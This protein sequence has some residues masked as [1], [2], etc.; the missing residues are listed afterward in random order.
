MMRVACIRSVPRSA[1]IILGP[2]QVREVLRE[3]R[4]TD[5]DS[6][7]D[8]IEEFIYDANGMEIRQRTDHDADGVFYIRSTSYTPDGQVASEGTDADGDGVDEIVRLS[9]SYKNS[10]F[11]SD[12]Y[13]SSPGYSPYPVRRPS[14]WRVWFVMGGSY[15]SGSLR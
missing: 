14:D 13:F 6:S 10:A 12:M 3:E 5:A 9:A 11:V 15:N 1:R 2:D 4:D 8:Y 7:P